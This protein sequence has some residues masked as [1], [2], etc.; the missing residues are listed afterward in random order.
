MVYRSNEWH[1]RDPEAAASV[2]DTDIY[3][4]LSRAEVKKRRRREGKNKIWHIKKVSATEY[5]MNSLGDLTS[6]VLVIAALTAAIFE[7]STIAVS[8]CAVLVIGII[9]RVATYVKSRRV[10]ERLADESIPSATVIRE[11]VTYVVRADM[12]VPGDVIVLGPGDVVPADGRIVSGDEIR[13]SERGI[14]ENR[15][16]VIKGDTVILT[17]TAGSEIPCEYRVNMLFAGS[18]ILSGNCRIIATACGDDALVSMRRGGIL[19]PS[20]EEVPIMDKL[21]EWCRKSVVLMLICVLLISAVSV[22]LCLITG[23]EFSFAEAFIDA[24]ALAAASVGS[25]LM[26]VGYITLTVP[27]S[28]LASGK[29]RRTILKDVSDIEKVAGVTSVIVADSS[30]FKSGDAV[31]GSCYVDGE[32]KD[33]SKGDVSCGKLL[34]HALKVVAGIDRGGSLASSEDVSRT[35][36]E[37]LLQRIASFAAPDTAEKFP[38]DYSVS[39]SSGGQLHNAI[40]KSETEF[41][42]HVCGNLRDVLAYCEKQTIGGRRAPLTAEDRENILRAAESVEM[43]GGKVIAVAHRTSMYTTLKRLSALQSDMCF[44]GFLSVEESPDKNLTELS[45]SIKNS[46]L[47]IVLLS[48]T[49][50]IDKGYLV[51]AGVI[52]EDAP[53]VPCR[54]VFESESLPG[55]SFIVSVPSRSENKEK[56]DAAAKL[57]MGTVRR[58]VE[59]IE[60]SAVLTDEPS[61]SGMMTDEAVGVAISRSLHRPIPQTLKRKAEISVYPENEAGFG[62]FVQTVKIITAAVTSLRNLR[63]AA[64][65]AVTSQCARLACTFLSIFTERA[66]TNA[67]SILTLGMIFDFLAVLVISFAP[68]NKNVL[69]GKD[70]KQEIPGRQDVLRQ[71]VIGFLI[72]GTVFAGVA[73]VSAYT[74]AASGYI[75]GATL[76]LILVQLVILSEFLLDGGFLAGQGKVNFAY[77]LFAVLSLATVLFVMFSS[78]FAGFFGDT[79]PGFVQSTVSAAIAPVVLLIWET[80]KLVRAKLLSK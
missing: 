69:C 47:S 70:E 65:Y 29:G 20:G 28:R 21:S 3:S 25:Y 43:R 42:F 38:V 22:G 71:S 54:D 30:A 12:L 57:R 75:S 39:D 72:G 17:D 16:T 59:R 2:L 44:D 52:S 6:L 62:G 51:K 26:M 45:Q 11:G 27:V 10:L 53:I 32:F 35:D 37:V 64:M 14:T 8:V 24:M 41:E 77:L 5:A 23:N 19:I 49:P 4:G 74:S 34:R 18:A 56:I 80:V 78:R 76:S 13:V 7:R 60:N 36:T 50:K 66:L 68:Q 58:L 31:L 79:V 9:M 73:L 15:T 48:S 61:E 67:A 55:G 46:G 33:Y 63:L 1:L 40:M